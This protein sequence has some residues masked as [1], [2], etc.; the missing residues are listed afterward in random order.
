M[1]SGTTVLGS[2]K[3]ADIIVC[4]QGVEEN[5]CTIENNCGILTLTANSPLTAIDGLP[6]TEPT[7]LVQG[8]I[9]GIGQSSYF[10]FN[11]P[12]QARLIKRSLPD[13]KSSP[14]LPFS[15]YQGKD[16]NSPIHHQESRSRDAFSEVSQIYQDGFMNGDVRKNGD[17]AGSP[18]RQLPSPS[19]NRDPLPYISQKPPVYDSVHSPSFNKYNESPK[20]DGNNRIN[21][22]DADQLNLDEILALC[23]EYEKQVQL[24]KCT[25]PVQNRI[26]TNGS[27]PR[28]KRLNSPSSPAVHHSFSFDSSEIHSLDRE[29]SKDGKKS[30]AHAYENVVMTTGSPRPRIKTFLNKDNYVREHSQDSMTNRI[31][32]VLDFESHSMNQNSEHYTQVRNNSPVYANSIHSSSRLLDHEN[33]SINQNGTVERRK[34][35][36][37]NSASEDKERRTSI[38]DI[39]ASSKYAFLGFD[40]RDSQ[41]GKDERDSKGSDIT[42]SSCST[43]SAT[44]SRPPPSWASPTLD[45][46]GFQDYEILNGD[47]AYSRPQNVNINN[48]SANSVALVDQLRTERELLLRRISSLKSKVTEL[49]Q[50]EEEHVREAEIE[51]ALVSG[52]IASQDEKLRQEEKKVALLKERAKEC[53]TEMEKCLSQQAESQEHFKIVCESHTAIIET[54]ERKIELCTDDSI[55]AELEESLRDQHE[56]FDVEKRGHE[57]LEFQLMEVEAGWLSKREDL[58]KELNEATKRLEE[59]RQKLQ[60]LQRSPLK[61]NNTNSNNL[62]LQRIVHLKAIEEG[63]NRLKSIDEELERLESSSPSKR[64]NINGDLSWRRVTTS[65]DD[66]DRISR[67]T[68]G[69]PIDMGSTNSLGRRTIASLQEIERNRQIHL[70]KQGSLV[71]QE[72]RQRVE[73]LKKRVQDEV[74]AQWHQQRNSNCHS[75]ASGT[76]DESSLEPTR[77]SGVSSEEV[78]KGILSSEDGKNEECQTPIDQLTI[79][80]TPESRPLSDASGCSDDQLTIKLRSK[81]ASNLQRPLT[82]YLPIK[83]ESLDLRQHIESAGHQ[84]DLCPHVILDSTSCRGFL[85]KMASRFHSHWNKRWFV[86]DRVERTLTYYSDK[87]EK[88]PKGGAYFQAIEEVYVDHLNTFKSPNPRVTFVVKTSARTYH[89]VAPSPEAMRIWVD[90]IFTGAEGHHQ[91]SQLAYT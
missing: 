14:I 86:F 20:I 80:G 54:L 60:G 35:D 48:K 81:S 37:D 65:Q 3:E 58:Q 74:R 39:T 82:R 25:K 23:S 51:D 11:H 73:D 50:Q 87:S 66:L 36:K 16:G 57:L 71:I 2:G 27:L 15:F 38:A 91:Y 10:R 89:L 59:R 61:N 44:S 7:R 4:G 30:P 42:I 47:S 64:D 46:N 26:K 88:K 52:E 62:E 31:P 43:R 55:K 56:L 53:E 18:K 17:T 29:K 84:V 33:C 24:E 77:D 5:H 79:S 40:P 6:V 69:A 75:L 76:S 70:A 63:R 9:I 90:V 19:Y 8:C 13:N 22:V 1:I 28:E 21:C 78:E 49:E 83:S 45:L 34:K 32:L 41:D 67:I 85:N 72:E 12:D 68:S